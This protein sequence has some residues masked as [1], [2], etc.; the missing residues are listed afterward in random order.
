[1]LI[2]DATGSVTCIYVD[3]PDVERVAV[4]LAALPVVHNMLRI[5]D[6]NMAVQYHLRAFSRRYGC[7]TPPEATVSPAMFTWS[8][9]PGRVA[10]RVP[11]RG[12]SRLE[13]R[14]ARPAPER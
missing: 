3:T 6:R 5:D 4:D 13:E 1:M 8:S 7:G 10:C 2:E 12:T 9:S 11:P 14:A